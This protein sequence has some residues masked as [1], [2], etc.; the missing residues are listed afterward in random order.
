[1]NEASTIF[2]LS[3]APGRAGVAVIRVSGP[4]AQAALEMMS[5]PL[6]KPRFAAYRTIK[7]PTTGEALDRA[8][9]IWFKAPS[10]ET[11]EDI[12]EFQIHGSRAVIAAILSA[13]GKIAGC[14]LAEPGEFARRA[15]EN[16]KLDLAEVEGLA[17]LIDAE[18]DAQRRQALAQTA[19]SLSKIYESWRTRL[20][21]IA[22]L[23]EAAIDFSDEGDVSASSFAE[24]RKRAASLQKEVAAHL[25]DGHRGEILR[26]GFRVA[27]LGPP[28]AGKSS[29]LNVLARREAAIVSAEAGT[30]RDVIEVRLDLAGL[31]VIVSDTAGIREAANDIERE[32]IRRSLAAARDADLVLWLTENYESIPPLSFSRETSLEIRSKQDLGFESEISGLAI[33]AKTGA[34]IDQLIAEIA[35]RAHAAVGSGTEPALTRARHREALENALKDIGVFLNGPADAI[36]LRAEDV[37]RAAH[38]LGR[39]TGRVDVEDVLD[40]IFSRFCIGK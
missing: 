5:G 17:D 34:G 30:T 4:A 3:S 22:A 20:I 40:Q 16:G 2:A 36:E 29:L 25:D 39:I 38:A 19:G 26:D 35:R 7:H 10:T 37:R 9:V 33:S 18:T 32:G 14:R 27:L 23:T 15:F 8:V 28:N 6:P 31:P 12:A 21:E 13:L 24:A 11:G 1:M